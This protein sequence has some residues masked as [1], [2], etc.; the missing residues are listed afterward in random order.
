MP[1]CF[2]PAETTDGG[3][4]WWSQGCGASLA[5]CLRSYPAGRLDVPAAPHTWIAVLVGR[6]V[7]LWCRGD[8]LSHRGIAVPG[9]VHIVP[10]GMPTSWE[11]QGEV[12]S[13]L[14]AVSTALLDRVAGEA[15]VQGVTAEIATRFLMRD[16]Q[17][18][19]MGWVLKA[20]IEAGCPNGSLFID[21]LGTAIAAHLLARHSSRA[22]AARPAKGGMPA[23]KLKRILAHIEDNV[24]SS[25]SLAHLA[26]VAD[27]SVSHLK[28]LFRHSM[29]LPVHEY[30][31]RR[32][33]E[34]ART[35]LLAGK[36][37]LSQIALASGFAHQSHLAR[38]MRRVL[39]VTPA[40]ILN[41]RE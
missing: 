17:I 14:L 26:E 5:V 35:L 29:G 13:L 22:L 3:R 32:R 20:E 34:R 25:L 16:T 37:S 21:S 39:G 7:R 28:V 19:H 12:T 30:V 4:V 31:V 11:A 24:D 6:P 8:G 40:A 41:R 2:V 18:E 1:Y 38:Q 33:I 27:L 9:D 10:A 23:P 15:D 36:L